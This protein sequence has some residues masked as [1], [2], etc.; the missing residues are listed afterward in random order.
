[1]ARNIAFVLHSNTSDKK[2]QLWHRNQGCGIIAV[3]DAAV[4]VR[5]EDGDIMGN[6]SVVD[7]I[8]QELDLKERIDALSFNAAME[9]P[10]N[11]LDLLEQQFIDHITAKGILMHKLEIPFS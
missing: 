8:V 3:K 4:H 6:T 5:N 1:L 9:A 11:K 10:I 7:T 2:A